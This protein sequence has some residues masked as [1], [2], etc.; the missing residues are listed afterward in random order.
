[1]TVFI[2]FEK[3]KHY[4]KAPVVKF[5]QFLWQSTRKE[6]P[7]HQNKS[8]SNSITEISRKSPLLTIPFITFVCFPVKDNVFNPIH[9]TDLVQ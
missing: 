8:Y 3:E 5:E 7:K 1:M 9:A 4:F 2:R 6:I